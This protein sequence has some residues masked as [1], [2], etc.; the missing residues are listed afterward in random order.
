MSLAVAAEQQLLGATPV[1][2]GVRF[3]VW[4]TAASEL[5][6]VVHDGAAAGTH[7]MPLTDQGLFDRIVDGVV[8]GDR[9]S[10]RIDDGP[11]RPD[12]ASRYQPDGVHGPS[13]VI[14]SAAF[15]WSDGHW[16]GR[17]TRD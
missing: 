9:Y 8:A 6:L 12:P 15:T 17:T 16:G 11:D 13:Q 7:P 5:T 1:K 3:R 2:G 14:D 10:Y 4:A